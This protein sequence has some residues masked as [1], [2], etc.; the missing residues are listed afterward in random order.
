MLTV[1]GRSLPAALDSYIDTV[2]HSVY[3][4]S[5]IWRKAA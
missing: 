3:G 1:E 4:V 2:D 5:M